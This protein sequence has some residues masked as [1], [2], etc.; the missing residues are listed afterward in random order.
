MDTKRWWIVGHDDKAWGPFEKAQILVLVAEGKSRPDLLVCA[1]GES[2]WI[3]MKAVPELQDAPTF[4]APAAPVAP[5]VPAVEPPASNQ[6]AAAP[7]PHGATPPPGAGPTGGMT[8]SGGAAGPALGGAPRG[9]GFGAS[10]ATLAPLRPN[11]LQP[12]PGWPTVLLSVPTLGLWGLFT[13][14]RTLRAYRRLARVSATSA[15]VLFWVYAGI[16]GF[17]LLCLIPTFGAIWVLLIPAV[18]VGAFL[19]RETLR[20][21]D[22]AIE[23]LVP[24]AAANPALYPAVRSDDWHFGLWITGAVLTATL[25]GAIVGV[26]I[27]I[28]Q[29]LAWCEDWN[30]LSAIARART[31]GIGL[32]PSTVPLAGAGGAGATA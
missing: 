30:R 24:G 23:A 28:A 6:P 27:L 15:E 13:F 29:A 3:S 9:Q 4:R 26:P 11:E 17:V 22:A 21:R 31:P 14:L 19:L 12:I 25:F 16:L 8:Y 5:E 2:R 10:V 18:I 32:P 7:M 1:E 20:L